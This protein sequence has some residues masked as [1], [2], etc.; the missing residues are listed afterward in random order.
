[1][2]VFKDDQ[3]VYQYIGKLFQDLSDDPELSPKFRARGHDRPVPATAT[4]TRRSP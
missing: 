2:P 3:E 1:M 4:P